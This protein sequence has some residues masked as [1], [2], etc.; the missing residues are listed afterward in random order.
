MC[1]E[2][3]RHPQY[4]YQVSVELPPSIGED[5]SEEVMEG[6]ADYSPA[7]SVSRTDSWWDTVTI[8]V[9]GTDLVDAAANGVR[10]VAGALPVPP[11]AMTVI[12]WAHVA[13]HEQQA[14]RES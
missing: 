4:L 10:V 12:G 14:R 11:V 7:M 13:K 6:L 3:N 5:A 9:T 2:A 8:A 1:E